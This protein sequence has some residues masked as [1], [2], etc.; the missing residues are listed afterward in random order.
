ML[1]SVVVPTVNEQ[2]H[3]S[4][5][6]KRLR[7]DPS[8]P[9]IKEIIVVDAESQDRTRELAGAA[10][11]L[12]VK[13]PTRSRAIQMNLGSQQATGSILYFV[14]ADTTPPYGFGQKIWDA[15]EKDISCGCFRL[16]FD[17]RHWFLNFNSWFTRF[18]VRFFRFGDQSLFVTRQAFEHVGGFNE[19]MKVFEDQDLVRRLSQKESFAVLPDYVVTSARKY[20]KNGPYRLQLAYFWIYFMFSLGLS[21][22][23]LLRIYRRLVPFPMI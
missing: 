5:L 11:A 23:S 21:Q 1:I 15:V 19:E 18:N 22:E 13:C 9:L 4:M 16:K 20:R 17:W 12:L 6:I 3:I 10:G 14:H 7:A 8:N 2:H